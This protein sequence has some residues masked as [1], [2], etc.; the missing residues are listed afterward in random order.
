M[1]VY[2]FMYLCVF[3]YVC[4]YVYIHMHIYI[5]LYLLRRMYNNKYIYIYIYT[6]ILKAKGNRLLHGEKPAKLNYKQTMI[7]IFKNFQKIMGKFCCCFCYKNS[8]VNV[9]EGSKNS[10]KLCTLRDTVDIEY[11]VYIHLYIH[12]FL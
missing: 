10:G 3:V 6:Y 2:L 5:Y 9:L 12:M 1:F 4:L 7:L 11:Q 8:A